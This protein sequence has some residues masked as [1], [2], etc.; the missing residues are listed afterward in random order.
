MINYFFHFYYFSHVFF[1][2]RCFSLLKIT[3]IFIVSA[4]R[5]PFGAFGGALKDVSATE[6]QVIANKAAI[7]SAGIKPENVD[8][9]FV[10]NVMQ[11]RN[12][13]NLC[14]NLT[15]VFY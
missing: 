14:K 4:K 5:T 7:E 1:F 3:G 9:V 15:V 11:V 2:Q 6:L 8:S 13:N 10:G 12:D